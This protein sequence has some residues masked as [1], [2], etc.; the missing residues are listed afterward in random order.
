MAYLRRHHAAIARPL[1]Q[2]LF[3]TDGN[4][5]FVLTED[6]RRL[7]DVT[8]GGQVA[9]TIALGKLV[10]QLHEKV[11]ELSAPR[12]ISLR[13]G[14]RSFRVVLTPDLEEGGYS[15]EVPEL[16]GCFTQGNSVPEAREMARE[17]IQLFLED[18]SEEARTSTR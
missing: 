2:L 7:L 13:V 1:A 15:V 17:A 6:P 16:P 14:R 8:S 12:E 11:I 5:I 4:R 9:F 10:N 3:M 18:A